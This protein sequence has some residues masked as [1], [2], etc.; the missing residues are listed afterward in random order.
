MQSKRCPVKYK[1]KVLMPTNWKKAAKLVK[2]GKAIWVKDKV[3]GTYLKL[4]FDPGSYE[5]QPMAIAI[6]QG[7]MFE[8][9]L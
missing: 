6:D 4:K 1:N 3:L 8:G 5:T 9:F 7:T 2:E